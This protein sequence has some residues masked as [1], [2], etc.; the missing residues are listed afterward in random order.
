MEQKN[1]SGD[2]PPASWRSS[3]DLACTALA[4]VLGLVTGWLDLHV[5]EVIVTILTLIGSGLVVGMIQPKAAWRWAILIAIGLPI[6]AFCAIKFGFETAEP[7]HLDFRIAF[8]ALA[9]ALIGTYIGVLI[10]YI[11]RTQKNT[12]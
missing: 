3:R 8:V 4:L 1:Q 11:V 12:R 7:V 2:H 5:T 9:V 10:I 6:L